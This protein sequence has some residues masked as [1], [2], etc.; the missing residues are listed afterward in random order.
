[1]GKPSKL[2]IDAV[3]KIIGAVADVIRELGQVP[4]GHLY[5]RLMDLMTLDRFQQILGILK[6]SGMVREQ[7][8]LLTWTGPAKGE[9]AVAVAVTKS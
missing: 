4:S 3:V 1:M 6:S 7:G 8:H 2:E 5:A 9:P